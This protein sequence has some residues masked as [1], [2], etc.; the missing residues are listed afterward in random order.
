MRDAVTNLSAGSSPV[1]SGMEELQ[2]ILG[3]R[4]RLYLLIIVTKDDYRAQ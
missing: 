4:E 1:E 3:T 2:L